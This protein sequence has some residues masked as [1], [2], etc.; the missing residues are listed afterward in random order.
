ME[1]LILLSSY[2]LYPGGPRTPDAC[3]PVAHTL[4]GSTKKGMPNLFVFVFVFV[5]IFVFVFVLV[6]VF[7]LVFVFVVVF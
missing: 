7:A 4:A 6:L 3:N 2:S 1:G 5:F